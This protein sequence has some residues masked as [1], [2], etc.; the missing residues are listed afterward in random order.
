[1]DTVEET[2]TDGNGGGD[3]DATT[4]TDSPPPAPRNRTP[5]TG[6]FG[7]YGKKLRARAEVLVR[8]TNTPTTVHRSNHQLRLGG[9]FAST[10]AAPS[11][12][13]ATPSPTTA[14]PSATSST[15]RRTGALYRRLSNARADRIT[16]FLCDDENMVTARDVLTV[17]RALN[18][19]SSGPSPRALNGDYSKSLM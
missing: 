16:D 12:T 17:Q 6:Q 11:P 8:T 4:A 19:R 5:N 15:G 14:T 9:K 10:I 3:S 7:A 13:P 1:M 2:T 18:E